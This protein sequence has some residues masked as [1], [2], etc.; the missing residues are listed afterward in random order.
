MPEYKRPTRGS[1]GLVGQTAGHPEG[2]KGQLEGQKASRGSETPT[3]WSERPAI[4]TAL[5]LQGLAGW[6]DMKTGWLVLDLFDL[7]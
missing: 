7:P 1:V 4:G 3:G 2:L 6:L 5:L